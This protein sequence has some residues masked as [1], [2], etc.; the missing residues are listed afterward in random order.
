[1]QIRLCPKGGFSTSGVYTRQQSGKEEP[2]R[3][4]LAGSVRLAVL[5]PLFVCFFG[6]CLITMN[7]FDGK[8]NEH[9]CGYHEDLIDVWTELCT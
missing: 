3:P 8:N 6:D 1:M 7:I 4:E 5:Q 9:S 2:L